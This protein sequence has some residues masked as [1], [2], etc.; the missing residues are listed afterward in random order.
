MINLKKVRE[1]ILNHNQNIKPHALHYVEISSCQKLSYCIPGYWFDKTIT[2]ICDNDN[3]VSFVCE[4]CG[5]ENMWEE[6]VEG[7]ADDEDILIA[8]Q[9]ARL[10]NYIK[11]NKKIRSFLIDKEPGR[12]KTLLVLDDRDEHKELMV[13][14]EWGRLVFACKHYWPDLRRSEIV[15]C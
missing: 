14:L 11:N 15:A 4:K 13:A 5:S 12:V 7:Y 3:S 6:C 9:E 10:V 1:T 2:I 8:T